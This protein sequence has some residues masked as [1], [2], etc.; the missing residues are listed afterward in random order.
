MLH[1]SVFF[2]RVLLYYIAF[3]EFII[4]CILLF[5]KHNFAI[6]YLTILEVSDLYNEKRGG[7]KFIDT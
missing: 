6:K 7:F 1:F 4:S 5:N 2:L 3:T